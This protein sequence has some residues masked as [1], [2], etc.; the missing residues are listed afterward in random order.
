MA[1]RMTREV[2]IPIGTPEQFGAGPGR[3]KLFGDSAQQLK[4]RSQGPSNADVTEGSRGTW[5]LLH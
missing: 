3:S 1:P 5:E 2:Q 4:V